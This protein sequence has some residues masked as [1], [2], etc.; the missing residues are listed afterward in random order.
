MKKKST[1]ARKTRRRKPV[2]FSDVIEQMFNDACD[3]V[4]DFIMKGG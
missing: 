3:E 2:F 4:K 1:K